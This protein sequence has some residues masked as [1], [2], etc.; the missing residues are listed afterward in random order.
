[1]IY[2]LYFYRSYFPLML[3]KGYLFMQSSMNISFFF[4]QSTQ[5]SSCKQFVN[6]PF[7]IHFSSD[8]LQQS[9][10]YKF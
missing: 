5:F 4:S 9:N 2:L 3:A 7:A 6:F 8:F 10:I 1:M